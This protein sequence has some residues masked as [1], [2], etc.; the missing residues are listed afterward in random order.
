[1]T[2]EVDP[3]SGP[4]AK[5]IHLPKRRGRKSEREL[6][7][8]EIELSMTAHFHEQNEMLRA[9]NQSLADQVKRLTLGVERL[10]E[11]MHGVRTGKKTE[12]FA[13]VGGSDAAPDLP[14]VSA[15]AAL[16]YTLTSAD[17]GTELGFHSSQIGLLLSS[18]GLKWADNGDYQEIGRHHKKTLPKF[19]HR[20]VTAKLKTVLNTNTPETYGIT[21]KSVL[22]IF[23]K[24]AD[25]IATERLDTLL[26]V[27]RLN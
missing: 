27:A 7:V 22:A 23:R 20:D 14:T 2:H 11:E 5:I 10:V 15:E 12:A 13:R 8:Q 17:I 6:M 21:N 1:M 4:G 26:S 19:W 18:R 9:S 25:R 3:E 24:W 16:V